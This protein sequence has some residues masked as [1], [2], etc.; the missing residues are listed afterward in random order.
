[1]ASNAIDSP[2]IG[3]VIGRL[4]GSAAAWLGRRD[5]RGMFARLPLPM[6]ALA[7]SYGVA[8]FAL[9]FVPLTVA[10]IEAAAFEV[11]YI[12]LASQRNLSAGGRRRATYISIGAVA[13]S[14]IYNSM[15]S[16]FDRNPEALA[17]MPVYGEIILS[18]L[19]GAPLAL[20][21]YLVAD[22]LLHNGDDSARLDSLIADLR[23]QLAE[24]GDKIAGYVQS[25]A[26]KDS[27][28]ATLRGQG[29]KAEA[30][31]AAAAGTFASQQQAIADRDGQ[32][33]AQAQ[34]LA[35]TE[36]ALA[37]ARAELATPS[38]ADALTITRLVK[39]AQKG[40]AS[41][42]KIAGWTGISETTLRSRV[43]KVE[44]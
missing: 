17:S 3:G 14:I 35:A 15:S 10:L 11:T 21:A 8:R 23:R 42:S 29:A 26:G 24:A 20:V 28:I 18:V 41:W 9:F 19:H 40:G 44:D 31:I 5:W 37:A 33:A 43:A 32:I 13:V 34:R 36:A 7:A 22:L 30:N 25:I 4:M 12:G 16:F 39:Y 1:M 38:Q 27:E 2:G 6:L